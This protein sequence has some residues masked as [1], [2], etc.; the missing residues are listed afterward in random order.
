M[1]LQLRL[2]Y[3][4]RTRQW[5]MEWRC[6]VTGMRSWTAWHGDSGWVINQVKGIYSDERTFQWADAGAG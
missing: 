2:H 3:R 4:K 1:K 6:P 5:R